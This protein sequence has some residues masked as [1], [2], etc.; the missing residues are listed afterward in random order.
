MG[1]ILCLFYRKTRNRFVVKEINAIFAIKYWRIV[2]NDACRIQV[3]LGV[4]CRYDIEG[5]IITALADYS[6]H[7]ET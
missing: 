1:A 7:L 3:S 6:V 2:V 5:K 4:E